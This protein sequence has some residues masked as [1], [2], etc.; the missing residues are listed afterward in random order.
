MRITAFLLRKPEAASL[1]S[2]LSDWRPLYLLEFHLLAFTFFAMLYAPFAIVDLIRKAKS[3]RGGCA[4]RLFI[5]VRRLTQPPLQRTRARTSC[6][7]CTAQSWQRHNRRQTSRVYS[8]AVRDRIR[9]VRLA[10]GGKNCKHRCDRTGGGHL[11]GVVRQSEPNVS[12][13]VSRNRCAARLPNPRR[14]W[15]QT[16]SSGDHRRP[17]AGGSADR[18]R[19][20]RSTANPAFVSP[21][22]SFPRRGRNRS[23]NQRKERAIP[24][25]LGCEEYR[26]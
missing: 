20:H 5:L 19:A 25:A 3:W 21:D 26:G 1:L 22:G 9:E 2:F 18:G 4:N 15:A 10:N 6:E 14:N 24:R 11:Q 23:R 12:A 7:T 17:L 8:R 16:Q 13:F